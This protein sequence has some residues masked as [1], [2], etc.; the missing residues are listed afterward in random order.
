MS[1]FSI[2]T[3]GLDYR[4]YLNEPHILKVMY[5]EGKFSLSELSGKTTTFSG[6][7]EDTFLLMV[8]LAN[9]GAINLSDYWNVGD[10]RN[11][12]ISAITG[13]SNTT[14]FAVTSQSA[15]TMP[16]VLANAGGKKLATMT[17]G[18][19][20]TCEFVILSKKMLNTYA[21]MQ[22]VYH[23]TST[24]GS[25][26]NNYGG[27]ECSSIRGYYQYYILPALPSFLQKALKPHKSIRGK[28]GGS[29]TSGTITSIDILGMPAEY[30]VFG[31]KTYAQDDEVAALQADG[32]VQWTY[33]QTANNRKH[34]TV[35]GTSYRCWLSSPSCTNASSFCF[36]S[37]D[38][39]AL[40]YYA[41]DAYGLAF[42]G[43]L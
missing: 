25:Y 38:G 33:Y 34:Y 21:A 35:S 28:G 11:I 3:T 43:C 9:V 24:T 29:N 40:N 27:W 7:T 5:E 26:G 22:N 15:V 32:E 20:I 23:D 42:F 37:T 30:N 39:T 19:R 6:C 36:V 13:S 17:A 1:I 31:T 4:D 14:G 10:E 18:G 12:S 8:A 41:Y 16:M 2:D